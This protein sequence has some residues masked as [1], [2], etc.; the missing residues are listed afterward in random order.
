[1][2]IQVV[3]N[4]PYQQT[5]RVEHPGAP[6]VPHRP[7]P[8]PAAPPPPPRTQPAVRTPPGEPPADPP[9][10]PEHDS[11]DPLERTD[12]SVW[13]QHGLMGHPIQ[14][15]RAFYLMLF[16]G[17][18]NPLEVGKF[19]QRLIFQVNPDTIAFPRTR[20]TATYDLLNGPQAMQVGQLQLKT[21]SWSSFFP[22]EYDPDWCLGRWL[23]RSPR[24]CMNWIEASMERKSPLTFI[25]QPVPAPQF[26]APGA[27][28]PPPR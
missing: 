13:N 3:T 9:P 4:R 7:R 19:D 8:A 15:D 17:E 1:M 6:P 18:G 14:I 2:A 23:E 12:R 25:C 21:Y 10:P 28:R 16:R 26:V 5:A 24:E 20:A 27:R 22:A 11:T